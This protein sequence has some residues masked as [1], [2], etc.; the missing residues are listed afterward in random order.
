MRK[1]I[2]FSLMIIVVSG[3]TNFTTAFAPKAKLY[4]EI[5]KFYDGLTSFTAGHDA[6]VS[7]LSSYFLSSFTSSKKI[8]LVFTSPDNSFQSLA[9]E[10]IVSSLLS[11]N[12]DFK[13]NVYSCGSQPTEVSPNLIKVISNHGFHVSESNSINGKK[14]YEIKFG[15]NTPSIIIYSKGEI[16]SMPKTGF[17]QIKLCNQNEAGCTDL[18]GAKFKQNIPVENVSATT[19]ETDA[20]K[21]FTSI[22]SDIL[23]AF[24]KSKH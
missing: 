7:Y 12:K 10:I 2:Q 4:P 8:D 3:F 11:V 18:S 24:N 9:A 6:G 22:A 5:E 21:E 1:L 13:M 23:Y 14:T 16:E 19:S 20:D 17:C 15:D